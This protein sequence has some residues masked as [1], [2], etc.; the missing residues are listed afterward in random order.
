MNSDLKDF[1]NK[2]TTGAPN[3]VKEKKQIEFG[4]EF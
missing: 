1:S 4:N 2:K 3:A